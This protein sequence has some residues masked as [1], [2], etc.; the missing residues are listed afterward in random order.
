MTIYRG[1]VS[2]RGRLL[3]AQ[4]VYTTIY[5]ICLSKCDSSLQAPIEVD[6]VRWPIPSLRPSNRAGN[7]PVSGLALRFRPRLTIYHCPFTIPSGH[8]HL[9]FHWTAYTL[10]YWTP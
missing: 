10:I 5:D 7:T 6:S 1:L 9:Y 8:I 3:S 4:P 2:S